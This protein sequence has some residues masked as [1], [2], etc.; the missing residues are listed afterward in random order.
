MREIGEGA[1]LSSSSSVSDHV[2]ALR[3]EGLI[4]MSPKSPRSIRVVGMASMTDKDKIKHALGVTGAKFADS[5]DFASH[6]NWLQTVES[7]HG[8]WCVIFTFDATDT[9][10]GIGWTEGVAGA[11]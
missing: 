5:V 4:T 2:R 6:G 9:L 1:A 11:D 8:Q 7:T 3:R 10:V